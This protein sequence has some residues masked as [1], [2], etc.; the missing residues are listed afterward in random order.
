MPVFIG[1]VNS[2]KTISVKQYQKLARIEDAAR[3]YA[4]SLK[5][6]W[7]KSVKLQDYRRKWLKY[8][9]S[10]G[11]SK[12]EQVFYRVENGKDYSHGYY[13]GDSLA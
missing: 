1:S 10:I 6:E 7:W 12:N 3:K 9:E 13:F 4:Y 2:V 5:G 8:A 11:I